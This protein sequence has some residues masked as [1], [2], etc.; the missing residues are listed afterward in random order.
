METLPE[1]EKIS[2]ERAT[3]MLIDYAYLMHLHRL[4]AS[5][6]EPFVP[7]GAL[8]TVN[9]VLQATANAFLKEGYRPRFP[10]AWP[11]REEQRLKRSGVQRKR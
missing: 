11:H 6:E 9:E 10:L 3:N 2:F 4:L 8:Q 1:N 5:S 7:F